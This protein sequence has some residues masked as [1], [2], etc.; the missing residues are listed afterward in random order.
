[1]I[2]A[3]IVRVVP[4]QSTPA[5]FSSQR[6]LLPLSRA[7]GIPRKIETLLVSPTSVTPQHTPRLPLERPTDSSTGLPHHTCLQAFFDVSSAPG[8]HDRAAPS[9][10]AEE[11]PDIPPDATSSDLSIAPRLYP[12]VLLRRWSPVALL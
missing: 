7:F 11:D 10:L 2:A 1:M 9:T 3:A 8:D 12:S 4:L 5:V 6:S